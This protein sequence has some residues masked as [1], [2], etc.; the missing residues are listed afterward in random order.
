[1][2]GRYASMIADGVAARGVICL[3]YPFYAPGKASKPRIEH[4]TA[5]KTPTLIVQGTRDSMGTRE[6]VNGYALAPSVQVVWIEDGDHSLRPRK[7]SGRTEREALGEAVTA[8]VHF[9]R[10]L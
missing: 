7:R 10:S 2:G 3:G 5:Q 9:I 6:A 4:L 8:C 1:M